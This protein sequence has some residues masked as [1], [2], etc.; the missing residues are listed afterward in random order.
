MCDRISSSAIFFLSAT[1]G[2]PKELYQQKGDN[3]VVVVLDAVIRVCCALNNMCIG[4][5]PFQ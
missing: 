4:V 3:G 5:V 2:I 1:G